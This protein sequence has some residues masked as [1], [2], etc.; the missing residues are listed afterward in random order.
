M[1]TFNLQTS[2]NV[3]LRFR[4]ASVGDRIISTFIDLVLMGLYSGLVALFSILLETYSESAGS[5][6]LVLLIP[7]TLYHL[8][9]EIFFN[10]QSPGKYLMKIKVVKA[11][12]TP[13]SAGAAIIRW[14]FRIVDV[15][16]F[17][18]GIAILVIILNGKGQRLGDI[19]AAT[20]VLKV[21]SKHGLNQTVWT[22]VPIGHKIVFPQVELLND[23]DIRTIKEVLLITEQNKKQ[24]S[25]GALLQKTKDAVSKKLSVSSEM[26]TREFLITLV[27]DYNIIHSYSELEKDQSLLPR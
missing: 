2:Q 20:T 18:G 23:N 12:G 14:V 27:W 11:D 17:F 24:H 9:F 1:E 26:P 3:E 5:M 19:A 22:E 8:L 6:V 21:P 16:F 25:N 10:G 4:V 15:T 13:L 7:L